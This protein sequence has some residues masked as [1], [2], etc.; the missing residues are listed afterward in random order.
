MK[1]NVECASGS[2]TSSGGKLDPRQL[3][4]KISVFSVDQKGAVYPLSARL[5]D[6]Q[7]WTPEFTALA[8]EEYKR[9]I[10]LAAVAGHPVTPSHVVDEVWHMHLIY[11]RSYWEELGDI[12]GRLIH[13]DPGTGGQGDQSKFLAQYHRTL[14]SY[15]KHFGEDAPD[16]VWG[17]H[18]NQRVLPKGRRTIK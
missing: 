7:D 4:A 2:A 18:N 12:I 14:D 8:I 13:H 10:Y 11:T 1:E 3:W 6:E 9:F 15:R 5:S 17:P 16:E